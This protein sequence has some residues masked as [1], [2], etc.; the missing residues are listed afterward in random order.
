MTYGYRLN[1]EQLM[2]RR[3]NNKFDEAKK[4]MVDVPDSVP[5]SG[6]PYFFKG[7]GLEDDETIALCVEAFLG[8]AVSFEAFVNLAWNSHP[9]AKEEDER[10]SGSTIGKLKKLYKLSGLPYGDRKSV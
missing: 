2:L 5:E 6:E 10:C 7:P 4:R 8:W 3:A 9:V 1:V